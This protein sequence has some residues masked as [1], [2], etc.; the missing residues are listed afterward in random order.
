[1]ENTWISMKAKIPE[2]GQ[3]VLIV[4]VTWSG[5]HIDFAELP[6]NYKSLDH[7]VMNMD[8]NRNILLDRV[9]HWMPTHW[10]P[11]PEPPKDGDINE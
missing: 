1:M 2:V 11:L 6:A 7:P 5:K 3:R 4:Y 9:T 10:I 8:G